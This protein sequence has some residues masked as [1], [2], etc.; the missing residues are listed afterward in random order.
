MLRDMHISMTSAVGVRCVKVRA[1]GQTIRNHCQMS[2][3]DRV[4][5]IVYLRAQI[6]LRLPKPETVGSIAARDEVCFLCRCHFQSGDDD[7]DQFTLDPD[8]SVPQKARFT[9]EVRPFNYRAISGCG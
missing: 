9:D 1:W 2:K 7:V 6:V 8:I 5:S 3:Y 4:R